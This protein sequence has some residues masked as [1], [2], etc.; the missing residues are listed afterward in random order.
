MSDQDALLAAIKTVHPDDDTPRLVYADWLQEN[1]DEKQ[2]GLIRENVGLRTRMRAGLP[3]TGDWHARRLV[4]SNAVFA[5]LGRW[6]DGLVEWFDHEENSLTNQNTGRIPYEGFGVAGWFDRGLL[7]VRGNPAALAAMPERLWKWVCR[8]EVDGGRGGAG[9]LIEFINRTG[10]VEVSFDSG[11]D[12]GRVTLYRFARML[13]DVAKKRGGKTADRVPSLKFVDLGPQPSRQAID[14][15]IT[16]DPELI[17][18]IETLIVCV[19]EQLFEHGSAYSYD[20]RPQDVERLA[21]AWIEKVPNH[22]PIV[23]ERP[24]SLITLSEDHAVR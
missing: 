22:R 16:W 21:T 3:M 1:G 2:A 4:F 13:S 8:V 24:A 12:D 18:Q 19:D 23:R 15:M 17:R 11:Y 9:R 10:V 14:A 7:C 5:D 6:F 20:I